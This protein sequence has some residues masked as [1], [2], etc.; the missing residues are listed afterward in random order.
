MYKTKRLE[1]PTVTVNEW[2]AKIRSGV[3][4]TKLETESGYSRY[5]IR[6][7]VSEET[8]KYV[9]RNRRN[10]RDLPS[11][12][13]DEIRK[14]YSEGDLTQCAVAEILGISPNTVMKYTRDIEKAKRP[15]DLKATKMW[16][17]EDTQYI[18][19]FYPISTVKDLAYAL[20]M[21][22]NQV[23]SRIYYL[24]N[25]GFIERKYKRRG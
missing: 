15:Y 22:I 5:T 17:D 24:Q 20:D 21:T 1:I 8:L 9:K 2:E 3:P 10:G 18:I 4:L 16:S 25:L 14:L 12:K 6:R 23:Q 11:E 13:I 19:D 7:A